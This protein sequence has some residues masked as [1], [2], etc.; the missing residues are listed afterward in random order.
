M[1]TAD[2]V[3]SSREGRLEEAAGEAPSSRAMRAA[4]VVPGGLPLFLPVGGRRGVEGFGAISC[5]SYPLFWI[6]FDGSRRGSVSRI[7]ASGGGAR[8]GF[9]AEGRGGALAKRFRARFSGTQ[10]G[11]SAVNKV[12]LR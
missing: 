11:Y 2:G 9:A 1:G 4:L 3:V 8:S 5:D 7:T 10:Q 6:D 12:M